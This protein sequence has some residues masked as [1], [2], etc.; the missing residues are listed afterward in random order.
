MIE[1]GDDVEADIGFTECSRECCRQPHRIQSRV[2]CEGDPGGYEAVLKVQCV[3]SLALN[4]SGK[5]F[6]FAE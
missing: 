6:F 1:G 2:D 4:D 3:G 5:A